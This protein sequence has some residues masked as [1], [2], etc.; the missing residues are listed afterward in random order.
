MA[1]EKIAL[2]DREFLVLSFSLAL[3][4]FC[5]YMC[6][7]DEIVF[8]R[9]RT[10]NLSFFVLYIQDSIENKA[11]GNFPPVLLRIT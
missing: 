5:L 2:P 6:W 8:Y 1:F 11:S 9:F 7:K 3:V 10:A 4:R